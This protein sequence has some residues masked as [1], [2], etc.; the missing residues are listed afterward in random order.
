MTKVNL[1]FKCQMC[2]TCC[3]TKFLCLYPSEMI[4]ADFYAHELKI[5]LDLEP[6]RAILDEMS[7]KIIVL[8]YRIKERPCPFLSNNK[9]LIQ[10]HKFIACEKYPISQWIDLGKTFSLLGLNNEFYD[11]DDKCNFIK[12][13][14][15]FKFALKSSPL[16]SILPNEYR[17]VLKDKEVWINL[18]NQFKILK[19]EHKIKVLN[20]YKLKKDNPDKYQ[21]IINFWEQVPADNFINYL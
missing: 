7:Q 11:I 21:E 12:T 5:K 15:E 19:K 17:A 14:P 9:C 2:G 1:I 3:Q 20:E 13:N 6:L 10:A 4:R 18:Q 8:I 16:S